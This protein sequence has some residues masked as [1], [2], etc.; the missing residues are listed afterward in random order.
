[1]PKTDG[2][3]AAPR[4]T[5]FLVTNFTYN[6]SPC[7]KPRQTQRDKWA[8]RPSVVKYRA[9]RDEIRAAGFVP[10]DAFKVTFFVPMPKSWSK[11]KRVDMLGVSHQQ[12]PDLDNYL[13]GFLDCFGEDSRFWSVWATKTWA[14]DTGFIYVQELP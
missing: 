5:A 4:E 12:R 6:V 1:M 11:K 9:F 14:A 13:K 3:L 8:Q 7:P 10:P 2:P